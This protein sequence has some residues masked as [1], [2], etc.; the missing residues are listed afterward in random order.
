MDKINRTAVNISNIEKNY[1]WIKA[2]KKFISKKHDFQNGVEN[3]NIPPQV[4]IDESLVIDNITKFNQYT[5]A[6]VY[7]NIS[8][9]NVNNESYLIFIYENKINCIK[10]L[11]KMQNIMSMSKSSTFD[12]DAMNIIIDYIMNTDIYDFKYEISMGVYKNNMNECYTNISVL[13][14]GKPIGLFSKIETI[15]FKDA[16]SYINSP[17]SILH[18]YAVLNDFEKGKSNEFYNDISCTEKTLSIRATDINNKFLSG[19]LYESRL[20]HY[21][22][23][24]SIDI[25]VNPINKKYTVFKFIN[26]LNEIHALITSKFFEK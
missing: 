16:G 12:I 14:N 7:W 18:W 5:S 2:S 1:P 9:E 21:G 26:C 11:L 25:D 22:S 24:I 19:A 6:I 8:I 17:K 10:S 3:I 23:T 15:N 4:I 20:L 13:R